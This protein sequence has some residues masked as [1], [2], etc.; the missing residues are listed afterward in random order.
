MAVHGLSPHSCHAPSC[1][2]PLC[3]HS[4]NRSIPPPYSFEEWE[5]ELW[6]RGEAQSYA[7]HT[8]DWDGRGREAFHQLNQS[9]LPHACH[10]TPRMTQQRLDGVPNTLGCPRYPILWCR[11]L[12]SMDWGHSLT[13]FT[14]GAGW[15]WT[16]VLT[17]VWMGLLLG[18]GCCYASERR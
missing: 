10:T 6:R 11:L 14:K 17:G 2:P 9:Q 1:P 5:W 4:P 15:D 18:R 13:R 8:G 16:S 3:A 7:M 12:Y